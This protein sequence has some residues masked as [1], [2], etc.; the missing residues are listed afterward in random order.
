LYTSK[1][2]GTMIKSV[3]VDDEL[4]CIDTL[5]ILLHKN[6]PQV[7]IINTYTSARDTLEGLRKSVPDLLFLDIEMPV[8]NGFQMLE[9]LPSI[10]FAIVFTTSYDQYAIRAIRFSALDFLL[11]PIDEDELVDAVK[12]VEQKRL[13]VTEQFQMLLQNV[14]PKQGNFKKIAIPTADGFELIPAEN[15]IRCEAS[16]NYTHFYLRGHQKIIVCRT[17]KEVEEQLQDFQMFIRV[18]HGSLINLNEISKY[19]KG[20]GGYL[21]MSD[22]SM[23]NVSRRRKEELMKWL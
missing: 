21:T 14:K 1:F 23:V 12:K 18:H 7:E 19:S 2:P 11:K 9:L 4:P 10:P 15:I 5:S 8:I 13:P 22:G 6:C 16:D 3:I 17:L 20:E